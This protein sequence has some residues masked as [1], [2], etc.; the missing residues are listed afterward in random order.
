[1]P[2]GPQ[3][4][5]GQA[6]FSQKYAQP[7]ETFREACNRVASPLADSDEHYHAFRGALLDQRFIPGGRIWASIGTTKLT[8]AHNC[9]VSGVIEDS[10]VD[11]PGNIMQRAAEAAATMRMGGGIGYDFSGLRPRGSLIKK[12]N[13]DASGPVSFMHIFDAV[14]LATCSSG[15]RRGAQMGVLRVDHPDIEEFIHAKNNRE[16]LTGFNISVAITDGFMEAVQRG[17]EFPLQFEGQVYRTINAGALWENIMRSAWDWAEPGVLFIDRMNS[18]NNLSYCE[19]ITATNPCSEQ[20]LPP[21]GACL[22][23][24]FNLTKYVERGIR[25]DWTFN[26]ERMLA[27][28]PHVVRA[29]DNVNSIARYPLPEQLHEAVS[30]RRMG[31][32]VTGMANAFE[33]LGHAYGSDDFIMDMHAVLSKL[34]DAV[35]EAS[36]EL[37]AS[38]GSFPLFEREAYLSTPFIEAMSAHTRMMIDKHGIRNSHLI[39]MAPTGTISLIADNVSS[40]IEPVF[41]KRLTNTIHTPDGPQKV[42]VTDYGFA[43]FGT[44]PRTAAEVSADEHVRVL[45]AAQLYTD[46]AVSKTCNVPPTMPWSDFKALYHKAWRLGAKSCAVFNTG[47]K[48]AGVLEAVEVDAPQVDCASGVCSI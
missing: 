25:R 48:R 18:Q 16:K 31:I 29:M 32:G 3:T 44:E 26:G 27:D 4:P 24:S 38:K 46:S 47:G 21:F 11:G 13:S 37:A 12:L 19:T 36:A 17:G 20:P 43:N 15:H 1:M 2:Y 41:A 9:F 34:R 35:Y 40:G 10:F 22:L 7:G 39:S 33:A 5:V 30:K 42:E 23:G 28:V 14:C 6:I 8:C 45:C